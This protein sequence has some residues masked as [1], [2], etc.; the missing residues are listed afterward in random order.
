MSAASRFDERVHYGSPPAPTQ[1]EGWQTRA[2][3]ENIPQFVINMCELE[4]FACRMSVQDDHQGHVYLVRLQ[5][6]REAARRSNGFYFP[7]DGTP[8]QLAQDYES[9]SRLYG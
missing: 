5:A 2:Y 9:W 1:E 3:K 8:A 4:G 6:Y 7:A